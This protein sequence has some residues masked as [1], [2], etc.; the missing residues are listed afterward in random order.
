MDTAAPQTTSSPLACNLCGHGLD[1]P[2][3][4][5]A[6]AALTSINTRSAQPTRVYFCPHCSHTMTAPLEDISAF[7][8][9]GYTLGMHH[10]DEDQL[11][12]VEQG[13][14]VYRTDYQLDTLLAKIGLPNHAKVLD[15]GGGKAGTLKK[16]LAERPDVEGYVCEI[17]DHYIPAWRSFL[18][19]GH[20]AVGDI[21]TG[22][23]GSMDA[24]VSFFMLEHVEDPVGILRQ[25]HALLKSGGV[26]YFVIPY[27]Y[28]NPADM[29][30]ADHVNHFSPAS[31]EYALA[32]AGFADVEVDTGI[33]PQWMVVSAQKTDA[34]APPALPEA[35]AVAAC[36]ADVSRI[37]AYWQDMDARLCQALRDIPPGEPVAIYGAGFYGNFIFEH[38]QQRERIACFIDRNPHL[39]ARGHKGKPVHAPE[40]LPQAV[41]HVL[42]G[43]NP[44]AARQA[45]AEIP[46][47]QSRDIHYHYLF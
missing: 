30:I 38:M 26:V 42:V 3:Y 21:P 7:Y 34:M 17:S 2:V 23:L 47:W 29:L 31:V 20:Y 8:G 46:A 43:I 27:L 6:Q 24:V 39:Q 33:N 36:G 12:K 13:R 4:E 5:T 32:E 14:E 16:L 44:Q 37:A 18:K 40:A 25:Q 45:M 15:F 10:E 22:W 19:E 11:M 1:M 35:A 28:D 9:E 41:R